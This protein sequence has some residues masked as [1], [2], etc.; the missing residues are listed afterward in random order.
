VDIFWTAA[1][2]IRALDDSDPRRVTYTPNL[3]IQ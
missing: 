2:Q 3:T 1:L